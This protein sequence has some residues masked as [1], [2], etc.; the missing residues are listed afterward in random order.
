MRNFGKVFSPLKFH[1]EIFFHF[2]LPKYVF[3][4]KF[5]VLM[6]IT[7][8]LQPKQPF[9]VVVGPSRGLWPTFLTKIFQNFFFA[10]NSSLIPPDGLKILKKWNAHN[11]VP[12]GPNLR[13]FHQK[14]E[15][16]ILY[17]TIPK[18][19]KSVNPIKSYDH[20]TFA[21]SSRIFVITEL[22]WLYNMR[23]W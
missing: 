18:T 10:A 12:V 17:T 1:L 2:F 14:I 11:L 4:P 19:W 16:Q 9:R 22:V 21:R 8:F 15:N 3:D 6:L 5:C 20:Q 23:V 7:L 13:M